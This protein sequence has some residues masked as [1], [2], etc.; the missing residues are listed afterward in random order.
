MSLKTIKWNFIDGR[1][2]S[3]RGRDF[4]SKANQAEIG[5]WHHQSEVPTTMDAIQAV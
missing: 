1:C 3:F 5:A 2:Y 4:K